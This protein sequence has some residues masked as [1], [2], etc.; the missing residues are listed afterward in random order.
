[1]HIAIV[2][3]IGAGKTTLTQLLAN[4]F[5]YEPQFEAVDN[6]P[7]LE[8]FY[9][10]MKRWA[11]NLQIFFLN[12]RFRHIVQL[13]E[14]GIDM[15]QDRTIYED[16]YIF[17]ENL[18]DMGLM[19]ERDFENYS[20]IFQ[21]IIHYIKPP[22][23]LIYLKASVPTLVNN[24]QRRGRDYESA[25]RLDYLSKLNDKYDKW[26]NNYKDGKVMILDKDNLDFTSNP[27]DLGFIIQK[28]EAELF[29]LF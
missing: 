2:G 12:S 25:I 20:N 23:L 24:I 26:I 6:N 19:S 11:F 21:S 7:Y 28:I 9:A 18:F 27:E 16:A 22:D 8:D 10:D 15:I 29:G 17:A 5:K 13:Q 14:K 3:N 1:M 4:H